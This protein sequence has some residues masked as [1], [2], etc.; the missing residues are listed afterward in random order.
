MPHRPMT[1]SQCPLRQLEHCPVALERLTGEAIERG[2]IG[3]S[4][5]LYLARRGSGNAV[6]DE[7]RHGREG[8]EAFSK[9]QKRL[10][11]V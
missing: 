3:G 6:Y 2:H 7:A 8:R 9:R 10:R 4:E 1:A 11:D 5:A